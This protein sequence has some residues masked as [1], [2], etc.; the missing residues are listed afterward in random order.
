MTRLLGDAGARYL[1]TIPQLL[2]KVNG[3]RARGALREV[4]VVGQ[5][6]RRDE[7]QRVVD[8]GFK[9]R[10]IWISALAIL[11][12]SFTPAAQWGVRRVRR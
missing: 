3:V 8:W 1:T 2:D 4:F 9:P 12:S 11:L 6:K 5:S 7:L 10:Q